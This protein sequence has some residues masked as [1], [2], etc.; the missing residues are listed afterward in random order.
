MITDIPQKDTVLSVSLAVEL[1]A[2]Y[3]KWKFLTYLTRSPQV[4]VM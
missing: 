3:F 4:P 2:Y 1:M